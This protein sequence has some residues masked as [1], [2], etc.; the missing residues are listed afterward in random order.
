MDLR[1]ILYAIGILLCILALGMLFPML[2]DIYAANSDWRVFFTCI[3]ITS[4][5]GGSLILSTAGQEFNMNTKQVFIF[6][7]LSWLSLAIF[8]SLPLYFSQLGLSFTDSF[9]EAMSGITTTGSTVITGLDTAPPGILLWRAILQ[10]LGGIGI[11]LMA[12]SVL[13]FLNVGGMQIFRTELS[14]SEKA[15][16]RTAQLASMIGT[17]YL[18]LT[19]ACALLYIISG[20]G[21]FD[22]ICH[23]LT[24]ISTGGFANFDESFAYY[25]TP[26]TEAVSITFML[27]G[28]MPFVLYLKAVNGN[29]SALFKDTQV[30]WF[31]SLVSIATIILIAHL[32]AQEHFGPIESLRKSTFNVVS[33]ITGTGYTNG[34]YTE[35]GGF[36]VSLL[37]FLM[38]VGGCAGSTSCGIK[39]FRF[40]VL[41]NVTKVQIQ[42]LIIQTVFLTRI[43]ITVPSSQKSQCRS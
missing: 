12:M 34:N 32:T 11:I 13:P 4:F 9:F 5:F 6:T 27:L 30:I 14:E 42:K 2:A 1:P 8:A 41:Y 22:S 18:I 37:F 17:I 24:T 23:A 43:T 40:Q 16:P 31:L 3:V 29:F 25:N 26:G 20:M 33:L 10:W 15:L 28:G 36:A 19:G 35:W 21:I 7:S 39:I 38:V